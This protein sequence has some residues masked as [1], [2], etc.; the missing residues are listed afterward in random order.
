MS[1]T[2]KVQL[3]L[4]IPEQYRDKLRK[5]AAGEILNSPERFVTA[6]Q[7]GARIICDFL[8]NLE[9]EEKLTK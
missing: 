8:R 5:M 7:I 2:K 1:N 9:G 3:N 4:L 6:S